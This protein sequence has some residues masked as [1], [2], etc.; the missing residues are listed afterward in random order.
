[1]KTL[2]GV[3]GLAIAVWGAACGSVGIRSEGRA[4]VAV[5][6]MLH[7]PFSSLDGD[8]RPVGVEVELVAAA[9]RRLGREV[10]WVERPFGELL[11]AVAAGEAD[12][13]AA[14]IGITAERARAVAFS[15]PYFETSI[16]ALVRPD[17]GEPVTL[18]GLAG[19]RVATERGTTAVDALAA[20]VPAATRILDRDDGRTWA[21]LLAAGEVDAVVLDES[22]APKFIANAGVPFEV[23]AEPL[24]RELFGIAV[25]PEARELLDA[26]NEAIAKYRA[27]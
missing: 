19:R 14:T 21:Q 5:S 18:D 24:R 6:N 26:L 10:L 12:L 23:L 1:M 7:P 25:H 13:A 11:A 27:Q 17:A 22:H 8:G 20:R 15:E 16:V 4:L 9:A 2:F 3:V